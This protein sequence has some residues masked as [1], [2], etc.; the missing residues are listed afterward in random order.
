MFVAPGIFSDW[1]LIREWG[2]VGS[3]ETIRKD[4]FN[5]EEEARVAGEKLRSIKEKKGYKLSKMQKP[6]E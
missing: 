5:I 1:S 2:R 4:W 3:P 6:I